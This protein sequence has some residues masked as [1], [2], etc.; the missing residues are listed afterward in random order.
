MMNPKAARRPKTNRKAKR[1][2]KRRTATAAPAETRVEERVAPLPRA[3]RESI[4]GPVENG[5]NG[6]ADRGIDERTGVDI[7]RGDR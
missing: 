6:D 2:E 5:Q 7:E 3:K 1:P 4:E